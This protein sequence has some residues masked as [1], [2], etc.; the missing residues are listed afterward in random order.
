M[1]DTGI[2]FSTDI[3]VSART[4]GSNELQ[5]YIDIEFGAMQFEYDYG[6]TWNPT[7][8]SYVTGSSGRQGGGWVKT[9]YLNGSNNQITVTNNSNFPVEASFSFDTSGSGVT[10]LNADPDAPHSVIGIFS[11]DDLAFY[12]D[13]DLLL[14]GR[15]GGNAENM[16]TA[17][18]T[19]EMDHS[20][21]GSGGFYYYKNS[22]TGSN[23]A[24]EFF[25]LSGIPDTG[26]PTWFQKVGTINVLISPS[27][28]V[29]R[30]DIP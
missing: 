12:N 5:Y 25:A 17:S 4:S 18:V 2:S 15:Y 9:P 22:A 28:G 8:H 21:V 30:V 26:G 11:D 6:S 29:T 7:T 1:G 23:I 27:Q 20:T 19:L 13:P 10:P 16:R 24:W 14:E 3:G